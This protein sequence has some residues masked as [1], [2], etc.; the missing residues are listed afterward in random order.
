MP[1]ATTA[2]DMPFTSADLTA[3]D[4]A[5]ASGE[6]TVEVEGK[7]VTYRSVAELMQAR[8]MIVSEIAL[9]DS[10]NAGSATRRGTYSVRFTTARG[11]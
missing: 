5:I 11:F 3:V 7:R 2:A 1:A 6:L 4:A 9:A 10:N 8:T